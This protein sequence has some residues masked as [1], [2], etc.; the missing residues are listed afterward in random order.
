MIDNAIF[1]ILI[2]ASA[3]TAITGTNIYTG[4]ASQN[5][6]E[7]YIVIHLIGVVPE[8]TKDG[9]SKLDQC[10]VQINSFHSN[11][12]TGDTL[13]GLIRSTLDRYRGSIGGF[14]IDKII[15]Q[16]AQNDFDYEHDQYKVLQDFIVRQ[17]R[18]V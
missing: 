13:A 11:K 16:D 2:A 1:Q 14:T 15:F 17:K 7:S 3:V 9:A 6:M 8:N 10:R 18:N 5:D 12:A 4:V